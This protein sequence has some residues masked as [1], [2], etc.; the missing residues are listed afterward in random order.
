M[1]K[2]FTPHAFGKLGTQFL[3]DTP[4]ANLW[5]K[6]GMGKTAMVLSMIDIMKIAGSA[7]F[8]ALVIGPKRACELAWPGELGKWDAFADLSYT[9]LLGEHRVRLE[10]LRSK[11]SDLYIINYDNIQ[12]LVEQFKDKWPFKTV[13]ADESRKLKGFRL[14][15]G[16]RRSTA[17]AHIAKHTG[18]WVNLT[19]TPA[20]KDYTDLW[21]QNWFVDFGQRLGRSYSQ[22]QNRY[23]TVNPYSR[24]VQMLPGTHEQIDKLIA[25]VTI[26]FRPE[27]WFE[28]EKPIHTVIECEMPEP[29]MQQYRAM[30]RKAYLEAQDIEALSAAAKSQK[31]LQMASGFV[32]DDNKAAHPVH[33]AKV[34]SLRDLV[35]ELNEPVLVA[36]FFKHT[37][38]M[39]KKAF[40][41][42][43]VMKTLKDQ[44]DWNAGKIPMLLANY[45]SVGHA[46]SLQ[47]G[48]RTV[49]RFDQIWDEELRQQIV[50]RLGPARQAQSG[51]KRTVLIYDLITRGTIEHEV[52]ERSAGRISVQ[53]ALMLAQT[54]GH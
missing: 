31:L 20:P 22:F 7:F 34:D 19:G 2:H 43:R 17:L 9:Q 42:A 29:A 8:P 13:I 15:R 50:E 49:V 35:E 12:W 16:T 41:D 11:I 45:A 38:E 48:G 5:A 51:H 23:C 26:A 25:D 37:E 52:L 21:G 28:Y 46:I 4:R 10:G 54:R 6:P 53:E 14:S 39:L 40:P 44:D 32:Y 30:A 24:Q 27:D 36:Y 33:F 18:R 1:R 47:D 3:L